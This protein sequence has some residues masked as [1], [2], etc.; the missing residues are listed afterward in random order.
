MV[1]QLKNTKA[2]KQLTTKDLAI[3]AYASCLNLFHT[4]SMFSPHPLG[5]SFTIDYDWVKRINSGSYQHERYW[6]TTEKNCSSIETLG[7]GTNGLTT[8]TQE[9]VKTLHPDLIC[10][11]DGDERLLIQCYYRQESG[12]SKSKLGLFLLNPKFGTYDFGYKLVIVPKPG[13]FPAKRS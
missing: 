2:D 1:Q 4:N 10:D 8:Y 13:L 6:G 11:N 9:K 3:I 12:F 5:I 7:K